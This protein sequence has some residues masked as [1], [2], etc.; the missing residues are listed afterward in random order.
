MASKT[1]GKWTAERFPKCKK[2]ARAVGSALGYSVAEQA[3][4]DGFA[5]GKDLRSKA[6]VKA[7]SGNERFA[8]GSSGGGVRQANSEGYMVERR[9]TSAICRSRSSSSLSMALLVIIG[10][11][12]RERYRLYTASESPMEDYIQSTCFET[13]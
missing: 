6:K 3:T 2:L 13:G 4:T 5:M 10:S 12:Y 1:K 8:E 9:V 7:G 11:A